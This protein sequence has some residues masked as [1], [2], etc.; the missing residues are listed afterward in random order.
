MADI[1]SWKIC[2]FPILYPWHSKKYVVQRMCGVASST[3]ISSV[4]VEL[5]VLIFCLV[6]LLNTDPFPSNIVA[7]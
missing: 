4:S 6:E 1:L 7:P 3:A 2:A 5:F